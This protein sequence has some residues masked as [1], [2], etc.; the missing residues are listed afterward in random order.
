MGALLLYGKI[1]NHSSTLAVHAS[2]PKS[3]AVLPFLDLTEGMNEEPFAD[4]MTEELI[5][6]LSKVPEFRVPAPTSSFYFKDKRV[7]IADIGSKTGGR[8][9]ARR[10]RAQIRRTVT[11]G[12]AVDARG[13][14]LCHV[15][16]GV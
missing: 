16:G 6:K 8:V 11:G 1:T 5:D 15:V 13:R 14:W 3:I 7:P 10:K 9:C 12:G 2:P 4:G